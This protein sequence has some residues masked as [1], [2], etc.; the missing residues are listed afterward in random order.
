MKYLP[1]FMVSIAFSFTLLSTS[2]AIE[3]P[4]M[5]D[6]YVRHG[7]LANGLRYLIMPAKEPFGKN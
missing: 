2:Q 7:E 4:P 1:R 6:S 5:V 3:L